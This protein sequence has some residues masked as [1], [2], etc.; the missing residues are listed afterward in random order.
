MFRYYVSLIFLLIIST[1]SFADPI[2]T[3]GGHFDAT[4]HSA[5]DVAEQEC[6]G[7]AAF[8]NQNEASLPDFYVYIC[9][10]MTIGDQLSLADGRIADIPTAPLRAWY[11]IRTWDH[12]NAN[13]ELQPDT[14]PVPT[15]TYQGLVVNN[16]FEQHRA[17]GDN[18]IHPLHVH[19]SYTHAGFCDFSCGLLSQDPNFANAS[20]GIWYR[21][22]ESTNTIIDSIKEPIPSVSYGNSLPDTNQ[23]CFKPVSSDGQARLPGIIFCEIT[24]AKFAVQEADAGPGFDNVTVTAAYTGSTCADINNPFYLNKDFQQPANRHPLLIENNFRWHNLADCFLTN[25]CDFDNDGND[26]LPFDPT[27]PP[28]PP[29][30]DPIDPPP[31]G[32]DDPPPPPPPPPGGD[33]P[34]PPPPPPG[35]CDPS[36][37]NCDDPLPDDC[38]PS[39]EQCDQFQDFCDNNPNSLICLESS[40]TA[41]SDC[42]TPPSC[43]GDQLQCAIFLQNWYNMCHYQTL[44]DNLDL[45]QDGMQP[46]LDDVEEIDISDD[47][48]D[49]LNQ[50]HQF[51]ASCPADRVIDLSFVSLTF[52]YSFICNYASILGNLVLLFAG[53]S[54]VRIFGNALTIG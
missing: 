11:V 22:G 40:A 8:H 21:T 7:S 23:R 9:L 29:P 6:R 44:N 18:C 53:V 49:V 35:D 46:L 5:W 13:P 52:S 31:S 39:V 1:I 36:I 32:G 2:S 4:T 54:A 28:P 26:D 17:G 15:T 14:P 20:G 47:I 33:D 27:P 34:P 48:N 12:L 24:V 19:Y 45:D 3:L 41:K 51:T 25:T 37:D 38:D 30:I 43:D 50:S 42:D 16:W 10:Y